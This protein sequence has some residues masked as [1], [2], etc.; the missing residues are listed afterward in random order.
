MGKGNLFPWRVLS[1]S[2][3]AF[4]Q[5][6]GAFCLPEWQDLAKWLCLLHALFFWKQLGTIFLVSVFLAIASVSLPLTQKMEQDFI[7]FCMPVG[8]KKVHK[9]KKWKIVKASILVGLREYNYLPK[10]FYQ[11][12]QFAHHSSFFPSVTVKQ[13]SA[14]FCYFYCFCGKFEKKNIFKK[15]LAAFGGISLLCTFFTSLKEKSTKYTLFKR[16]ILIFLSTKVTE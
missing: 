3:C 10:F 7:I 5:N 2:L 14:N 12:S 8:Q 9:T 11:K 16:G 15:K 4:R 1:G 6:W 13:N